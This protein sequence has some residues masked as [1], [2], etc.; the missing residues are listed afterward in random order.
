M[1]PLALYPLR[2]LLYPGAVPLP[3]PSFLQQLTCGL[4]FGHFLKRELE[5]LFIHSFS[6]DTMPAR[7]IFRNSGH[8]WLLSGVNV[9]YWVYSPTAKAVQAPNPL[10]LYLGLVLYAVGELGN[11]SNHLTL[12]NLRKPGS[13]ERGI[14]RGLGFNWVTCPNYFFE[15]VAWIGMYL[16]SNL[17]LSILFFIT[18]GGGMMFVWA[19]GKETRYRKLFGANYKKKRFAM[20]PFVC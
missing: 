9:A 19:K 8:Y 12:K 7:N 2:P 13:R 14:P 15:I 16:V 20:I 4:L 11:L 6:L 1:H 3:A 10:V 5:T 17:S 18:I